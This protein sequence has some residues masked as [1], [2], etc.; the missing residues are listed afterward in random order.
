MA[1][2]TELARRDTTSAEVTPV[3]FH[4]VGPFAHHGHVVRLSKETLNPDGVR[5]QSRCQGV[6]HRHQTLSSSNV[7]QTPNGRQRESR[8]VSISVGLCKDDAG[9][10]TQVS[11]FLAAE[12]P[13]SAGAP[14]AEFPLPDGKGKR[15][16]DVC[17]VVFDWEACR[18][19]QVAPRV[20]V[21]GLAGR[22]SSSTR[23]DD[24]RLN[25]QNKENKGDK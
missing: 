15:D 14:G 4:P 9:R 6:S 13:E 10:E 1:V 12:S 18:G 11:L 2:I 8:P 3:T 24:D 17:V 5:G 22:H 23:R 16:Q 19:S 20:R 7:R 21:A 25:D